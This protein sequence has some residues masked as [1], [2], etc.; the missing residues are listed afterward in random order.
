MGKEYN[1]LP[2]LESIVPF[3]AYG[4]DVSIYSIAYEAWRRGLNLKFEHIYQGTKYLLRYTIYN[5][6][7]RVK[8]NHTRPNIVTNEAV[9]ICNNS[10]TTREILEKESIPVPRGKVLK[11]FQADSIRRNIKDL[12]FPL[13]IKPLNG[14]S[15]KDLIAGISDVDE[16]IEKVGYLNKKINSTPIVVEEYIAG[17][18]YS[19]FVIGDKVVG[20]LKW[21]PSYVIGDGNK[22]IRRLIREKNSVRMKNPGTFDEKIKINR[23][24]NKELKEQGYDVQS[25]PAE[26][27]VI[28]LQAKNSSFSK[29]D[30]ID[31]TDELPDHLNN[32]LVKAVKAIPGLTQAGVE[33][34][35]N[36]EKGDYLILGI[37]TNPSIK[38]HLFPIKGN[39]HLIPKAI[40]DYYFPETKDNYLNQTTP[41]YYFD[42]HFVKDYLLNNR[43]EMFTIPSYPYEPNLNSKKIKFNSEIDLLKIDR[44]IQNVFHQYNF[45]GELSLVSFNEYELS[46]AG[47]Y[48]DIA[49]FI[50]DLSSKQEISNLA[51]E[52]YNGPIRIGYTFNNEVT[53]SKDLAK[54]IAN[55]KREKEMLINSKSW[56]ITAPLRKIFNKIK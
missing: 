15:G 11:N 48:Q 38:N 43:L 25:V 34:V 29:G 37:N 12:T 4:Y 49:N 27:K 14:K 32:D 52:D 55:L 21:L 31:A 46:V 2:E 56:K 6:D 20:T 9:K 44:M 39:A 36:K 23:S 33:V 40:I 41:K 22:T 7:N 8:F 35:Y 53:D 54:E 50:D 13:L 19:A 45:N 26:G 28:G 47:N 24:L 30:A 3:E 1:W 51:S 17:E 42:F 10:Q 5:K 16:L 18:N